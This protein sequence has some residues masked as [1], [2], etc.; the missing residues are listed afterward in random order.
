[1]TSFVNNYMDILLERERGEI[2]IGNSKIKSKLG[3]FNYPK[4][5]GRK[6]F[7]SDLL[8]KDL[9]EKNDGRTKEF[10]FIENYYNHGQ[11]MKERIISCETT[12]Y[13]I[14]LCD[15][16]NISNWI[17]TFK[18]KNIKYIHYDRKKRFVN[19]T[20]AKI[21]LVN[22]FLISYLIQ[23]FFH[24]ACIERFVIFDP[25]LMK[26]TF[27][28]QIFYEFLWIVSS[29][30][31]YLQSL[32]RKHFLYNYLPV[33]LDSRIYNNLLVCQDLK[34]QT[35]LKQEHDLPNYKLLK[36]SCRE[37]M[38]K[39]LKGILDEDLY[40]LLHNGQIKQLLERLNAISSSNN[41]I[42]YIHDKIEN[43]ILEIENQIKN[44]KNLKS[45]KEK[46]LEELEIKLLCLKRKK[47]NLNDKLKEY[48]SNHECIICQEQMKDPVI[49]YCCQNIICFQCIVKWLQKK[50]NCAYCRK[51][52]HNDDIIFLKCKLE[53]ND[54]SKKEECF[55][56][57]LTRQNKV[58]DI[59]EK[60]KEEIMF[61][62]S[63]VDE[64][65]ENMILFCQEKD[66][67]CIE[68]REY[69]KKE[70]YDKI[71]NKDVNLII[72][73][74]Y[75]DLIGYEFPMIN[76]FICFPYLKKYVYKFICSRFYRIGRENDFHFHSFVT[77]S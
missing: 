15:E 2:V 12:K 39:I 33:N 56:K 25:E 32:D 68:L 34:I 35:N 8:T 47:T 13:S 57:L 29:E 77:F 45:K 58:F 20:E 75:K 21:I 59:I 31:I 53:Q 10:H 37:E 64:M 19:S 14:V 43:E 42:D 71:E 54:S 70:V 61:F 73:S 72:L 67:S 3:I 26:S 62:Y 36:H 65:T 51:V 48:T 55:E 66:I 30:P 41:I 44:Y 60:N 50:N 40:D 18:Q 28:P 17:R 76:H 24:R 6:T 16:E 4:G 1:M 46:D 22:Q 69:R 74:D 7:L 5:F 63:D 23:N 9:E 49:L 27:I 11:I 52:I 38:Y